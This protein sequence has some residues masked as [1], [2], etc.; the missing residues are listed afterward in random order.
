MCSR[1]VCGWRREQ[2]NLVVRGRRGEVWWMDGA[3]K[4]PELPFFCKVRFHEVVHPSGKFDAELDPPG[5]N[6]T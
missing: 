1:V 5:P 2:I 3:A 4:R 6:V